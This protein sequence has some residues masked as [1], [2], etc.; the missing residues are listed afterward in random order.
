MNNEQL[1]I[2]KAGILAE[3]ALAADIAAGNHSI[4]LDYMNADSTF[5]V[6]KTKVLAQQIM[7][8]AFIWTDVDQLTV[9][10]SRI[11]DWLTRFGNF[12]AAKATVRQ[13]LA[14]CFG[15]ASAMATA[16]IPHLKRFATRAEKLYATGTGTTAAPGLL[17]FEGKIQMYDVVQALT[18][19]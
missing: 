3:T 5:V 19:V 16:I 18:Q 13:G 17:V 1:L 10:K 14:D 11:W 6:W 4:I 7:E 15:A 8:D 2:L 9:G 12:N